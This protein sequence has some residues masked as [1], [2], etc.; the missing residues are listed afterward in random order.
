MEGLAGVIERKLSLP[1]IAIC[2]H[3]GCV[4]LRMWMGRQGRVIDGV[5]DCLRGRAQW[6]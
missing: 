4:S 5:T 3:C 1:E 2:F 6:L